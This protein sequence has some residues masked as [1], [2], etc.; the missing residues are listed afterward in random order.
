[1]LAHALVDLRRNPVVVDPGAL[2]RLLGRRHVLPELQEILLSRD[3]GRFLD[4][5]TASQRQRE[6]KD[7]PS[8]ALQDLT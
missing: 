5:G 8:P 7:E 6:K 3:A 1:V 2:S 4:P